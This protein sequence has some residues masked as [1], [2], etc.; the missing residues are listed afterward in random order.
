M[1]K[2]YVEDRPI[3]VSAPGREEVVVVWLAVG[4][5]IPLKEVA[6]AQLLGA[7][8]A[9]EVLWVPGTAQCSDDLPHNGLVARPAAALLRCAHP[10]ARH[11]RVQRAQHPLQVTA[12]RHRLDCLAC[13]VLL[14]LDAALR[15][16]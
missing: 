11:V 5:A 13:A 4:T 7:V 15:Y 10:L 14:M 1:K 8:G 16:L 2:S 9:G 12:A 3:A 6:R